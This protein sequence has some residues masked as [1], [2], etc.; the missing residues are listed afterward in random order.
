MK[1]IV[2]CLLTMLFVFG[3]F[4][5]TA[6]AAP[7]IDWEDLS[8]RTGISVELLQDSYAQSEHGEFMEV[9]EYIAQRYA[10]SEANAQRPGLYAINN[11]QWDSVR[12]KSQVGS[13]WITKDPTTYG[14]NHG[15]AGIVSRVTSSDGQR[16]VYVTEH[17]G[18]KYGDALSHEY[19]TQTDSI[20]R[21]KVTSCRV[22]NMKSTANGNVEYFKLINAGNYARNN[23][24]RLPYKATASKTEYAVN[25]A[26]LVYQAYKSQGISIGNAVSPTVLPRDIVEDPKAS[27]MYGC[28]WTANSHEW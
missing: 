5:T 9:V 1:R 24:Q 14:F 10:G 18:S 22:Y 13:V 6:F 11:L 23:L 12:N 2:S 26:T 4:G 8:E 17:L 3:V 7:A 15:H 21:Y 25:C 28:N 19:D 27:L 16:T 20:W